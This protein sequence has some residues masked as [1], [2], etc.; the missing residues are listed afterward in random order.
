MDADAVVREQENPELPSKAMERKFSLWDREYTV[1][2]LT[3]LTG[4]QIRSKQ[5]EFEGEVEQL[6]ADHRPGQI[7]ANRPALSYLN[8]KPPYTEEEWRKARE[9]IQN[10]AEKIRLRFDRAEGV[11]RTEEKGRYRSF[12]R[13]CIAALPDININIST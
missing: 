5:V 1:E 2:A 7:V 12:A 11:V 8:G 13:K 3:D 10:E 9:S 6:L 4:S